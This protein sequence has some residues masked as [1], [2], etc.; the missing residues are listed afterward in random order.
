MTLNVDALARNLGCKSCGSR[1]YPR[2]YPVRDGQS[3]KSDWSCGQDA[4]TNLIKWSSLPPGK[5]LAELFS[6]ARPQSLTPAFYYSLIHHRF[7]TS[8]NNPRT[9]P[10]THAYLHHKHR[11]MAPFTPRG[12][13][14][15]APRGGGRGGFGGDRGG[16][17]G[18]R[19][20]ARGGFGDRGRGTMKLFKLSRGCSTAIRQA[21]FFD[22][23]C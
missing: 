20:G 9:T 11:I 18:A 16:R 12:G 14:R 22:M 7:P 5:L 19:G 3:G 15:G 4:K 2:V 23:V 6:K 1:V 10:R 13:G 17:G 21:N 8:T